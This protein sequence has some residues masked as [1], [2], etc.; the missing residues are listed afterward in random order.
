MKRIR[1]PLISAT[2][3]A[4]AMPMNME[5]SY[6]LSPLAASCMLRPAFST[7]LPAWP[8]ALSISL[9]AFSAGP[10]EP[11]RLHAGSSAIAA[12]RMMR[13]MDFMANVLLTA[14]TCSARLG[15]RRMLAKAEEEAA[16][17]A[18][19]NGLGG[20]LL[21]L[22]REHRGELPGAQAR[23]EAQHEAPPVI[24]HHFVVLVHGVLPALDHRQYREPSAAEVESAGSLLASHASVAM[25]TNL[26]DACLAVCSCSKQVSRLHGWSAWSRGVLCQRMTYS[27]M[28]RGLPGG[29]AL[30]PRPRSS[31]PPRPR[32]PHRALSPCC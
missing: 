23:L 5:V 8:K 19:G 7:A 3:G 24:D 9:P 4:M 11:S 26:H 6:F 27:A 17:C 29:G 31:P 22:R 18:R 21:D 15:R 16:R 32:L 1:M 20:G 12:A 14:K 30:R 10:P 28:R 13:E 2:I 25:N